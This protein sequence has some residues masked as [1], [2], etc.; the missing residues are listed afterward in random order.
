MAGRMRM[1]QWI[2][3][4]T[5]HQADATWRL[6]SSVTLPLGAICTGGKNGAVTMMQHDEQRQIR[7]DLPLAH[8]I[9]SVAAAAKKDLIRCTVTAHCCPV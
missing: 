8:L 2:L 5:I 4:P 1:Q 9:C 6:V 3:L 7:S